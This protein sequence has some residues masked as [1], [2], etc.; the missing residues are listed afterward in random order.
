MLLTRRQRE[1]LVA[2]NFHNQKTLGNSSRNSKLENNLLLLLFSLC[3]S[4]KLLTTFVYDM[5][6]K[7]IGYARFP[8]R[9]WTY[10]S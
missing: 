10:S 9:V 2:G 8:I 5:T 6:I 3:M 4:I 7:L 1:T